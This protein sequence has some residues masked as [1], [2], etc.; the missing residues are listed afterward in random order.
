MTNAVS[1][2]SASALRRI[3]NW[4]RTSM[5][6]VRPN[7]CIL[8]AIYEELRDKLN[9]IDVVANEFCFGSAERSRLFGDFCQNALDVKICT[10]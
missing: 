1:E 10:F 6:Q 2:R 5:T 7:H 4:F 8:L 3:K 9:L